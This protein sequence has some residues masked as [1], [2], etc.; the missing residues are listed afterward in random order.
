M[1]TMSGELWRGPLLG[2]VQ[3]DTG[4]KRVRGK[5]NKVGRLAA[6]RGSVPGEDQPGGKASGEELTDRAII[7]MFRWWL[8]L[9]GINEIRGRSALGHGYAMVAGMPERQDQL[10]NQGQKNDKGLEFFV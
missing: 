9:G 4:E 10:E 1:A 5:T 7:G 2:I 3:N 8:G 6:K